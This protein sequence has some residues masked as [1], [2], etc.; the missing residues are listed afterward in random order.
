MNNK[1]FLF[2]SLKINYQLGKKTWFGTGGNCNLFLEVN[3]INQLIN[4]IRIANKFFPIL[5]IG[6]GGCYKIGRKFQENSNWQ[7]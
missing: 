7:K 1:T 6:S 3:S 4:T 5:I 2:K